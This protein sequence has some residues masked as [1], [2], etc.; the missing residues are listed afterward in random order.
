MKVGAVGVSVEDIVGKSV[1]G[2]AVVGKRVDGVN[3]SVG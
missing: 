1:E 3:V 2:V